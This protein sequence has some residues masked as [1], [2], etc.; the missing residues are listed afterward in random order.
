MVGQSDVEVSPSR[1][2]VSGGVASALGE[3]PPSQREPV[4]GHEA[5]DVRSAAADRHLRAD[6]VGLTGES[7]HWDEEPNYAQAFLERDFVGHRI[8]VERIESAP[9]VSNKADEINARQLA[10]AHYARNGG[11]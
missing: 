2:V 8:A 4:T 10:E 5:V 11:G 6:W 7:H 9:S 1:D 3:L